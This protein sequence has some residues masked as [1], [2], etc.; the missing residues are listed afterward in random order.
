MTVTSR[1]LRQALLPLLACASAPA[2]SQSPDPCKTQS[3]T[4]EINACAKQEFDA[5]DRSLNIAYQKVLGQIR[6]ESTQSTTQKLVAAQR[7]WVQFRDADCM[8]RESLFEGGTVHTVVY[9]QCLRDHTV[10]RIKDLDTQSWH[11]G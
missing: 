10:Q 2:W 11:G 1:V 6:T 7:L 5:Q 3:N 9:L 8:A 4:I